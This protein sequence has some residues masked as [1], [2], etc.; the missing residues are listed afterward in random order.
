MGDSLCCFDAVLKLGDQ[1]QSDAILAGI[2][3]FGVSGE[4]ATRQHFYR[5]AF[6]QLLCERLV[7]D[8]CLGARDRSPRRARS[9]SSPSA[10]TGVTA[11]N[12]FSIPRP[13]IYVLFVPPCPLAGDLVVR[14][15]RATVIGSVAFKAFYP[16]RIAGYETGS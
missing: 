1:R 5:R 15:H 3:L 11:A 9:R 12:F 13:V 14:R 8:G 16:L 2:T 10:R 7:I 6:Q 4:V